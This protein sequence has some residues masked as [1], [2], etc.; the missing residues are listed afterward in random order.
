MNDTLGFNWKIGA[1]VFIWMN[2]TLEK[3][4]IQKNDGKRR[5]NQRKK[6]KRRKW[7]R[8]WNV[9]GPPVARAMN[10]S[11]WL[12]FD[13]LFFLFRKNVCRFAETK[14]KWLEVNRPRKCHR[15]IK[16]L[17]LFRRIKIKISSFLCHGWME[18]GYEGRRHSPNVSFD[19]FRFQNRKKNW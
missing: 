13:S 14:R 5:R 10:S 1:F 3:L 11:F 6:R 19:L 4:S 15:I 18:C 9:S 2:Q 8:R 12:R 17:A 7:R 16:S